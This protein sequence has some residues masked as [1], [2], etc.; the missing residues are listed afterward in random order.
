[1]CSTVEPMEFLQRG[2]AIREATCVVARRGGNI[3][4][5]TVSKTDSAA[6]LSIKAS[7]WLNGQ[8]SSA[9]QLDSREA[10]CMEYHVC[11]SFRLTLWL[12]PRLPMHGFYLAVRFS[13]HVATMIN[14]GV[15]GL[16]RRFDSKH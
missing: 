15:G 13:P 7:D 11:T 12:V 3:G 4:G 8:L 5:S 9:M 14:L 10:L 16:G 1:M 6:A 2:V